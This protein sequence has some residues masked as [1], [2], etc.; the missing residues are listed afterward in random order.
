MNN[1]H[2][3]MTDEEL[4]QL[5]TK[6]NAFAEEVRDSF[7]SLIDIIDKYL[8]TENYK[9]ILEMRNKTVES[10]KGDLMDT[11]LN[12]FET[13][14]EAQESVVHMAEISGSGEET[15]ERAQ[16]YQS[17]IEEVLDSMKDVSIEEISPRVA[18]LSTASLSDLMTAFGKA[19]EEKHENLIAIARDIQTMA[20][21]NVA[22]SGIPNLIKPIQSSFINFFKDIFEKTKKRAEDAGD[23]FGIMKSGAENNAD[24]MKSE[25]SGKTKEITQDVL[26][27][28]DELFPDDY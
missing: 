8:E 25:L 22:I 28:I 11:F 19:I 23:V 21:E 15:V 5:S 17:Y 13:W 27:L 4:D 18:D 1:Y 6:I 14:T 9:P 16:E 26:D 3:R 10:Y 12:H 24:T 20:D 2:Y 7:V